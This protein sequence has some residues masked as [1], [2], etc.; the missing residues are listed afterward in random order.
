MLKNVMK[1]PVSSLPTESS[2]PGLDVCVFLSLFVQ[3]VGQYVKLDH[4]LFCP[5]KFSESFVTNYF[6]RPHYLEFLTSSFT[7]Q[8]KELTRQ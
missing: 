8:N 1:V 2:C 7:N 3:M 4:G 6:T 5:N